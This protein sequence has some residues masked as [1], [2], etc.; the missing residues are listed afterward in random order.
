MTEQEKHLQIAEI[1][2]ELTSLPK[3]NV[4]YKIIKGKEQPY[5]P[6]F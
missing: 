6:E 4:F 3:G 1:E 5:L 2:H